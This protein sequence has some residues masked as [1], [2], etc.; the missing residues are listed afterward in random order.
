MIGLTN[1]N[2]T[3]IGTSGNDMV[4]GLDGADILFGRQ[5]DDTLQGGNGNDELHGGS[6]TDY[7]YGGNGDDKI[8]D[9]RGGAEIHGGNGADFI[10]TRDLDSTFIGSVVYGGSGMDRITC[11]ASADIWGGTGTDSITISNGT[12]DLYYN[13]GD[14]PQ[15][16]TVHGFTVNHYLSCQDIPGVGFTKVDTPN[17][18]V[19]D[20]ATIHLLLADYHGFV[21]IDFLY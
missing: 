17:A 18:R 7:L 2:D 8:Y 9:T 1:G 4:Q 16:E 3:Y 12:H 10:A 14:T 13:Q 20:F 5:G 21:S 6:S 11:E 19:I 15:R